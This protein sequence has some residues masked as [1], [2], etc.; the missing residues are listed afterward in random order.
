MSIL[1]K[2]ARMAQKGGVAMGGAA[3][4]IGQMYRAGSIAPVGNAALGGAMGAGASAAQGGDPLQGAMT[5]ASLGL[6]LSGIG[7]IS[8]GLRGARGAL[9]AMEDDVLQAVQALRGGAP[10]EAVARSLGMTVDELAEAV[11][12]IGA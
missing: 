10:P 8:S 4:E 3:D 11:R 5:G 9:Q 12:R 7:T 6:G 1:G 2:L